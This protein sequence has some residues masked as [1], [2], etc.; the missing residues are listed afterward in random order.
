MADQ[1]WGPTE[2]RGARVREAAGPVPWFL[3]CLGEWWC[4]AESGSSREGAGLVWP[5]GT[6]GL[7]LEV[8]W[9]WVSGE[10]EK[11]ETRGNQ[12]K[13]SMYVRGDLNLRTN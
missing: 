2:W 6:W 9:V 10:E 7:L 3:R 4:F 1:A 5:E 12:Q 8:P 13:D 11:N